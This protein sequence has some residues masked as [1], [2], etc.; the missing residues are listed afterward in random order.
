MYS[1]YRQYSDPL[2]FGID[3]NFLYYNVD[4]GFLDSYIHGLK[5][6]FLKREDYIALQNCTSIDEMKVHLANNTD[7][8]TFLQNEVGNIKVDAFEDKANEFVAAQFNELRFHASEPF[9]TFLDYVTYE[10]MINNTLKLIQSVKGNKNSLEA[11]YKLHPLGLFPQIQAI[12]SVTSIDELY[13]LVLVDSPIGKFFSRTTKQDFDELSMELI[14]NLLYKNW[15]ESF[16]D[17]TQQIGGV[18]A[19]VMGD[20]LSFE[21]DQSVLTIT[22]N[23]LSSDRSTLQK[24][25]KLSLYPNFGE[26]APVHEELS[27]A[28]SESRMKEILEPFHDYAIMFDATRSDVPLTE[29]LKAKGVELHMHSF[30]NQFHFGTAFSYLK[31]KELEVRNMVLIANCINLDQKDKIAGKLVEFTSK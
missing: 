10:Y 27:E 5:N 31:L 19:E 11:Y 15:L 18:T 1:P 12:G 26:L 4:F 25:E 16:Y 9:S 30:E 2:L 8:G 24:D 14:K 3:W 6:C 23:S 17:F 22:K 7:Y 20:L 13:N 29:Q 21:A 28:K